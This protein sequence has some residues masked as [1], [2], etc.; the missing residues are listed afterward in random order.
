MPTGE[1]KRS[2][3]AV[4]ITGIDQTN[5]VL[6]SG[7]VTGTNTRSSTQVLY[8]PNAGTFTKLTAAPLGTARSN[9]AAIALS[10]DVLICGGTTNGT[11]T[12]SGCELYHPTSGLELLTPSMIEGRKDFGLAAITVSSINQIF[13]SG[14]TASPPGTYAETYEPN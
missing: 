5:D 7:G 6:I 3:T 10:I 9:H 1:D 11:D 2:H 4:R 8:D 12:I 13:A 14:G